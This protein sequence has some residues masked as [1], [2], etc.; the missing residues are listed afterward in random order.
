[1]N[2]TN[3]LAKDPKR[4]RYIRKTLTW[5]G[6]RYEVRGHTEEEA[7]LRLA[8]LLT[9]L[10]NGEAREMLTVDQWFRQWLELYKEP[11]GLTK[12]S[13]ET[14][15]EKYRCYIAPVIGALPLKEVRDLHLQ[16]ILNSQA[17]R[18]FS[19]VTK[20]RMVLQE[21]FRQARWSRL[22][23]YDPAEG[24]QLPACV[25]GS[26]RTIT[27]EERTHILAVA[28]THPAGLW[29]LT[30]LYTGL[31]PGETSP[32]LW[33]D[34][35]FDRNELH[36]YKALESGS[37]Q[38]KEPK[39]ESGIRD[40]PMRKDLRDRL[41]AVRGDPEEPVFPSRKGTVPSASTM[42]RWW[43]DFARA[44]DLHMGAV[45]RDG[46]IVR[47]VIAPDLTPYCLRHT[48]C[49]DLQRAEVPINVAKELMGHANIS[50]TANIYTHRDQAV[51]HSNMAKLDAPAGKKK[52]KKA[53]GFNNL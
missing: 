38:V 49:T 26:H 44:V 30:I 43:Y 14:Y 12:K 4:Y 41:W 50:V 29:V 20:L 39:T 25:K 3:A 19:H 17:G 35:D 40:I 1:M 7:C 8:Q 9:D 16:D 6:R 51:L 2:L 31:R 53:S 23:V 37:L 22:I 27:E 24:L 52:G 34:V 21:L 10:K 46:E 5:K 47:H 42:R 13:L 48:F 28:E 33:K 36:V 45:E 32:L 11:T 18:S 15:E